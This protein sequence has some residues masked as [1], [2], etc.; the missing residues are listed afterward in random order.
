MSAAVPQPQDSKR[1]RLRSATRDAHRR[2]DGHRLMA[3][4]L[5]GDTGIDRYKRLLQEYAVLCA[6]LDEAFSRGAHFLPMEF[7]PHKRRKLP[8]LEQDLAFFNIVAGTGETPPEFVVDSP[9]AMIG[10]VYPVEGATLGGRVIGGKLKLGLGVDEASGGRFFAG[11]GGATGM[12]WQS[13]C[14]SFEKLLRD[15]SDVAVA[16][17]RALEVFACFER[18]LDTAAQD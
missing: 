3:W 1:D 11:Y 13:A 16:I 14:A 8:W 9:A 4:L 7:E 5:A 12:F 15:D 6:R 18:A 17:N 10:L 2:L